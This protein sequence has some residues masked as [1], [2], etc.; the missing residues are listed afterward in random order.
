MAEWNYALIHELKQHW[1]TFQAHLSHQAHLVCSYSTRINYPPKIIKHT[2]YTP[3][4]SWPI[5]T[6]FMNTKIFTWV[7]LQASKPTKIHNFSKKITW[8]LPYL[9]PSFAECPE[10]KGFYFLSQLTAR[11]RRKWPCYFHLKHV[12]F[13]YFINFYYFYFMKPFSLI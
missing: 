7:L 5:A 12:L 4:S 1:P 11:R 6:C 10:L 8:T 9:K 3:L 13:I 2:K